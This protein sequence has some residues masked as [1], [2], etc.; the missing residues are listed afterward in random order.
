MQEFKEVEEGLPLKPSEVKL[1]QRVKGR[2]INV[3]N[4]LR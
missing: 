4:A 3:A 1:Q 2:R